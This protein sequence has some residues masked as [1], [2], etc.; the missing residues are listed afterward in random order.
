MIAVCLAFRHGID[1]FPEP[2]NN[3][4]HHDENKGNLEA[5]DCRRESAAWPEMIKSLGSPS[6]HRLGLE[7]GARGEE[8]ETIAPM[9]SLGFELAET[10]TTW[11][12]LNANDMV[13]EGEC[14]DTE[15]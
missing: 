15:S 14:P 2:E 7:T 6:A 3:G 5:P 12:G 10:S 9:T 4:K 8:A 13:S 11:C 1:L